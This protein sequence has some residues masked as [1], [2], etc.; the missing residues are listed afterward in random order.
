MIKEIIIFLAGGAVGGI[1]TALYLDKKYQKRT[2]EEVA[3]MKEYVERVSEREAALEKAKDYKE[4]N[5]TD[6]DE[7]TKGPTKISMAKDGE[8]YKPGLLAGTSN[9]DYTK[10][11]NR[12]PADGE[13]P[14]EEDI[15][16]EEYRKAEMV[17]ER[18]SRSGSEIIELA[19]MDDYPEYDKVI[20]YYYVYNNIMVY[21][22]PENEEESVIED[23]D[24]ILGE[25]WAKSG[26]AAV[27]D[28]RDTL[29]IRNY[30]RATDY[31]IQKV[32]STFEPY[33]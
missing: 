18:L 5:D 15:K 16:E 25:C 8:S 32:F 3:S 13:Y 10:F 6:G 26:F 27:D 21:G 14:T 9:V 22:E 7:L 11:Y 2:E 1:L 24:E 33:V 30:D 31:E 12:D 29:C 23:E 17:N 19:E 28:P 4:V 20:L